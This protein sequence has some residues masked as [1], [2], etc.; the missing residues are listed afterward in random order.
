MKTLLSR[1][2]IDPYIASILGMVAPRLGAAGP[3]RWHDAGQRRRHRRH[4]ADVLPARRP[5]G[6]AGRAGRRAALA[7]ARGGTRQHVPAVPGPRPDGA[8]NRAGPADAA[9]MGRAADAVPAAVDRAVLDRLH[10][11]RPRQR[12]CGAVRGHSVEPVRH[13][14]DAA[15]W[16]AC[17]SAR[18][19]A[20]RRVLWATS[21]CSFCCR[22][23]PASSPGR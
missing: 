14:A 16:R 12:G 9:A 5:A 7:P 21:W 20:S 15:A 6:A 13:P 17:C 1:L 23:S 3:R 22:S 4:R 8:R 11:D 18:T 2:N 10:L 19:A